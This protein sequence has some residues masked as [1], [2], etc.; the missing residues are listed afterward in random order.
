MSIPL[1]MTCS[2]RVAG[3]G[4]L[5]VSW[6]APYRLEWARPALNPGDLAAASCTVAA[7]MKHS[8]GLSPTLDLAPPFNSMR[9]VRVCV[10]GVGAYYVCV[11]I[12]CCSFCDVSQ[13]AF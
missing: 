11:F 10:H 6:R 8:V 13:T 9:K 4:S 2:L 12:V 3:R 1:S 7:A 5:H